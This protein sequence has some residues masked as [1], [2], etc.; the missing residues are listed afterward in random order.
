M[1]KKALIGSGATGPMACY[2]SVNRCRASL[3]HKHLWVT[4]L[5]LVSTFATLLS[6]SLALYYGLD[7][8]SRE[9]A[10]VTDW[11]SVPMARSRERR[12]ADGNTG[13]RT[14]LHAPD[15][16]SLTTPGEYS[17]RASVIVDSSYSTEKVKIEDLSGSQATMPTSPES[18]LLENVPVGKQ[19]RNLSCEFQSASDLAWY[20]RKPYTWKEVFMRVGHDPG[21]NPHKGFVGRSLDDPPGRLYPEGYGVYAEPIAR[22]LTDLGL[23]AKVYYNESVT[24]LKAQVASGHPVM[25]WATAGMAKS[26]VET[27]TALDGTLVRG[28]RGEH[29]YLIVGYSKTGVWVNDPW[30]G[31]QRFYL[32][33]IFMSSW[34]IFDRMSIVIEDS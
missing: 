20:Y 22:A 31:E 11:Q 27:W 10:R 32:W 33:S 13:L 7:P 29:T 8:G 30:D 26:P 15:S 1:A 5:L 23:S 18:F 25:V 28:A 21:G 14:S 9:K 3:G 24:W 34:D 4:S 12:A 19:E 6:V 2:S 17:M 16:K